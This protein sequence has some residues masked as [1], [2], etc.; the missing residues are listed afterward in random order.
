MLDVKRNRL[1]YGR[2]L[3]PPDGY[4]LTQAVATTYSIDLDTL[5]SI[6]VALYYAQ[7]LEGQLQGKDVQLIRAIQHTARMLTI[8][9]QEGQVKVPRTA[10]DI[11]AYFEDSLV[12][13]LPDGAF[14]SFHP[15]TW[16]LHYEHE[17]TPSDIVYRLIVL[18][19]NLTFDRSWDVAAYLE[20]E[21]EDEPLVWNKP[22][23]DFHSW[24]DQQRP[25]ENGPSFLDE[26]ARVYFK[27]PE[28]F[29]DYSFHPIGIPG[30][31]VNPTA[32][33]Q[34]QRLMCLS[35]FLH[36]QALDTLRHN[37]DEVPQILGRRVDLERLSPE[38]LSEF[39]CYC[40]SDIV[41]DGERLASAEEGDGEPLEQD[42]HAKVFLFDDQDKTT[43][44]LGSANATK[45]AFERN[46]EFLLELKGTT[47]ATR[48]S[49]VRKQLLGN[50]ETGELF[51][52]FA[53]DEGGKETNEDE[54]RRTALRNLEYAILKADMRGQVTLS[55]NQ[56][57]YDVTLS[58]DLRGVTAKATL[59]AS[60]RPFVRGAA[61]Q[62]LQFGEHNSLCFPN[63]NETSLS[64][65][66]HFTI[67]DD[68]ETLREFLVRIDVAGMPDSRLDNIFK[69]IIDSRDKFFAYHRFLLTDELSKE[70]LEDEPANKGPG[71]KRDG[72]SWEF[73]MPIFEQLLVTAS[74]NPAAFWKSLG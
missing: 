68:D 32:K 72:T 6:P 15:K 44:F 26:L 53:S 56:K 23:V 51:L 3:I 69:S 70:D 4:K 12:P 21:P 57:N 14:T 46:V 59:S 74:R 30:Y 39:D 73:D 54:K 10:K 47:P 42:L 45:A 18:S 58:I 60:V 31:E 8:Y 50:D 40:L 20:G 1:D 62:S 63:I 43:W 11:Y 34:S 28:Q 22:L 67:W 9:H 55:E 64:R 5:L 7:T 37:V 48:L 49:R 41:V 61:D 29:D 35:P 24:L 36:P 17:E 52:P 33:H 66:L 2:L 16:V 25:L 65:F 71:P 19:R 27:E 38:G 13:I